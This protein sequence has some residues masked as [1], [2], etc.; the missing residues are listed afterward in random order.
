MLKDEDFEK[1]I[2]MLSKDPHHG[3]SGGSS[4]VLS[5]EEMRVYKE[6]HGFYNYNVRKWLDEVRA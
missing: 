4:Q 3:Q 2:L 1:L 6:A 5:A